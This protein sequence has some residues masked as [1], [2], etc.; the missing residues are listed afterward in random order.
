MQDPVD[1]HPAS[2]SLY[3]I[4]WTLFYG[5][6]CYPFLLGTYCVGMLAL[7]ESPL[8]AAPLFAI[9]NIGVALFFLVNVGLM[10]WYHYHGDYKKERRA[11]RLPFFSI[12][13]V[14]FLEFPL[15]GLLREIDRLIL[16][17]LYR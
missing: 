16:N 3:P 8:W 5:L 13:F 2:Q 11:S 9:V 6:L 4:L 10:W 12:L 14:V 15:A 17:I 7:E 1:Q